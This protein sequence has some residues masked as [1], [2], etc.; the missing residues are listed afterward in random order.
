[1]L[2]SFAFDTDLPGLISALFYSRQLQ[3]WFFFSCG[4]N[5]VGVRLSIPMPGHSVGDNEVPGVLQDCHRLK[6]LVDEHDTVFLLTDTRESRWLPTLL[7][8]DSNKVRPSLYCC[9]Y[10]VMFLCKSLKQELSTKC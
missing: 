5:A 10:K 8:A 4:Q 3:M 6:E 2:G 7:C 1:M 9:D